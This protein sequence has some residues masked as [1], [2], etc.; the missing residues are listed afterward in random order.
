MKYKF[1]NDDENASIILTMCTNTC[2]ISQRDQIN[3][4]KSIKRKGVYWCKM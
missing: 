3:V 2:V 1:R 4:T